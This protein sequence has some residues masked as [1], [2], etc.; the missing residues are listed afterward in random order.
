MDAVIHDNVLSVVYGRKTIDFTLLYCERKTMEIAVHP[1]SSVIVKAPK[2]SDLVTIEKKI[3]KRAR[4]I[5]RQLNYFKQFIPKTP[6]RCYVSGETHLY[7]GKQYRLKVNEGQDNSVKLCRGFFNINCR[8][9]PTPNTTKKL[10]NQWYLEKANFQFTGSMNRCWQKFSNLGIDK[11]KLSIKRMQKRWGSLSDK[12]TITLNTDLIRAP[13]ECI[14]YVVTH[15]LC[16]L[17]YNDHSQDFYKL[18]GL[19]NKN[20]EQTKYKLELSL[21]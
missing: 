8:S 7:L 1:D 14:D 2:Y 3:L 9:E 11:P 16:H 20:W 10:L 15:E 6:T 4:W 18:L 5:I 13:K 19:M 17:K 12:G 21:S